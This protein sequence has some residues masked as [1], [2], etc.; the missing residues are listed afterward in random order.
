MSRARLLGDLKSATT[1]LATARRSLE[2][3][4]FLARNGM[5]NNLS[6][7]MHVEHVAHARW[8]RAAEA[9]NAR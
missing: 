3:A 6:F 1:D 7:A 2:D 9:F 4:K 5:T 8:Q